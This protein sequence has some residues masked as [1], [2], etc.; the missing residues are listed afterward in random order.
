MNKLRNFFKKNKI[1]FEIINYVC[2]SIASIALSYASYTIAKEELLLSKNKIK[3]HL[4]IEENWIYDKTTNT[5]NETELI[6]F[7]GGTPINNISTITFSLLEIYKNNS[8]L[9][10]PLKNYYDTNII[11]NRAIGKLR[12]LKGYNNNKNFFSLSKKINKYGVININLIQILKVSYT[13]RLNNRY[14][15]YFLN[16]NKSKKDEVVN[17]LKYFEKPR[18]FL[19]IYKQSEKELN[20]LFK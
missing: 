20:K 16:N 1:F 9:Y 11:N 19:S 2:I 5:F 13:D 12:T 3:P 17:Y 18:Y 10:I 7:N 6:L 15:E 8:I 14:T 4:Y